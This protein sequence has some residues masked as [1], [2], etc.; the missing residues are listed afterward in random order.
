VVKVVYLIPI[1]LTPILFPSILKTKALI[2][3]LAGQGANN[4]ERGGRMGLDRMVKVRIIFTHNPLTIPILSA[5]EISLQL[6]QGGMV[7][8]VGGM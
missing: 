8:K 2:N 5:L 4:M 3:R 7:V 6:G 1:P